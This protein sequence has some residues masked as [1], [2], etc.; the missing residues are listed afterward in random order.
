MVSLKQHLLHSLTRL[1]RQ[2][3]LAH[4]FNQPNFVLLEQGDRDTA[5]LAV[6]ELTDTIVA[7][8]PAQLPVLCGALC[9]SASTS[10]A[11]KASASR[12]SAAAPTARISQRLCSFLYPPAWFKDAKLR[13]YINDTSKHSRIR[14]HIR[15]LN[16]M[17]RRTLNLLMAGDFAPVR[18][19]GES[20][21]R[22]VV[23][24]SATHRGRYHSSVQGRG[25]GC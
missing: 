24:I 13:G 19:V 2:Q 16:L 5:R 21:R 7:L 9:D 20:A 22:S 6:Q 25:H 23:G 15:T 8:P 4:L 1:V 10:P 17:L 18:N 12:V 3:R 11:Q 14:P